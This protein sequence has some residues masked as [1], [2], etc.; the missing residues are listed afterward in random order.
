MRRCPSLIGLALLM[1]L[2]F[3]SRAVGLSVDYI[4]INA[5]IQR[6]DGVYLFDPFYIDVSIKA[7]GVAAIQITTPGGCSAFLTQVNDTTWWIQDEGYESFAEMRSDP[8]L[9]F[10]EFLFQFTGTGS[11]TDSITLSFDPGTSPPFS[12]YGQ[13]AYPAH[14]EVDVSL[15]PVYEWA[16]VGTCGPTAWD[17]QIV[18]DPSG[19]WRYNEIVGPTE[20]QWNPGPLQ[21][22]GDYA[23]WIHSGQLLT[24]GGSVMTDMGEA[25]E[26]Y[27]TF[28]T[29]NAVWFTTLERIVLFVDPLQLSWTPLSDAFAYD[30]VRGDLSALSSS[31]GS[32]STSTEE[33]LG[34]NVVGSPLAHSVEPLIPGEGYWYLVRGVAVSG[35]M[36]YDS[37]VPAQSSSRDAEVNASPVACL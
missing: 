12:G 28:E 13:I 35:G 9:G 21:P 31:S 16:C 22:Y 6:L 26:Y 15:Q 7:S 30:V 2:L 27:P 33:C 19:Q 3:G 5:G 18:E 8:C 29:F 1:S 11:E 20:T 36:T 4:G 34:E 32:F 24:G 10:G 14:S 25:L 23:L 17:L 37:L